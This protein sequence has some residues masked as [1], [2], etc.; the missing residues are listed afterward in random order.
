M[1][2][3]AIITKEKKEKVERQKIKG[4]GNYTENVFNK[5][6]KNLKSSNV[7]SN[8]SYTIC[9]ELT[10]EGFSKYNNILINR[11]KE[12]ADYKQGVIFY[13]KNLNQKTMWSNFPE[14]NQK[15]TTRIISKRINST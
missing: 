13:I 14:K 7:I 5:I 9:T 8:G 12:T 6:D 1:P 4:Y 3:K 10:G 2:E 15:F 11:Y